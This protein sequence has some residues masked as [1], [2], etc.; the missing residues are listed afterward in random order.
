[1]AIRLPQ[2]TIRNI[3]LLLFMAVW[4]TVVIAGVLR[5]ERPSTEDWAALGIGLGAIVALFRNPPPDQGGG[6]L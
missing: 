5:G 3:L 6:P 2:W 1:M 4:S